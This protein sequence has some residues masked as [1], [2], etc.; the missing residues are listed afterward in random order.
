VT[1]VQEHNGT[2]KS[3]NKRLR[4]ENDAFELSNKKMRDE[5][6]AVQDDMETIQEKNETLQYKVERLTEHL[7][8][9]QNLVAAQNK[10]VELY[11]RECTA[12]DELA[13]ARDLM[14]VQQQSFNEFNDIL[15]EKEDVIEFLAEA[16]VEAT[17]DG[18]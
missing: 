7:K 8:I 10:V 1:A 14:S 11:H 12:N 9:I 4:D 15:D 17:E 6:V 2:L 16:L 18:K 5:S 3:E 13:A